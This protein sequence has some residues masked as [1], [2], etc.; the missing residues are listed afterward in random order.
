DAVHSSTTIEG[1]PLKRQ[2]VVKVLAGK[3]IQAPERAITEVVNYKK[4][5]DWLAKR[6]QQFS[7]I[8]I[9]DILRLHSLVM[10]DLLPKQKV[11]HLRQGPI[12]IVDVKNNQDYLRYTGPTANKVLK[13]TNE[14]LI[15]LNRQGKK[16]HP[17]LAAGILHYEFVSIYPFTDGNGRVTRLLTLLFLR[18]N[19]YGLR[20]VLIPDIF[21]LQFKRQYYQALSLAKIY[22]RQRSADLTPWL[23]YFIWGLLAVAEELKKNITLVSLK[24]KSAKSIELSSAEITL[25][26][27]CKTMGKLDLQTAIDILK[28]PRRTAQRRLKILVDKG[29]LARKAKG[30]NLYYVC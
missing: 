22:N 15:W 4:A 26:D 17:V 14:L 19:H 9:Q 28:I 13:L 5:L 7:S 10:V 24:K 8:T 20:D 1:N 2:E 11:G 29:L 27:F 6:Q 23:D 12:Y 25:L 3:L 21:Y 18:L 16:L 30:K